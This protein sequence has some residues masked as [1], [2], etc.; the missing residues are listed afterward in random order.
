MPN[1]V[2]ASNLP[3]VLLEG[4]TGDVLSRCKPSNARGDETGDGGVE[5]EPIV[6]TEVPHDDAKANLVVPYPIDEVVV[7]VLL[8]ERNGAIEKR[9]GGERYLPR[10]GSI[11][12]E[13][14]AAHWHII[15]HKSHK[16]IRLPDTRPSCWWWSS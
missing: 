8:D 4:G 3:I 7:S 14:T 2:T 6:G 10:L 5:D 15:R 16:G 13:P 1:T 9:S 11:S 12:V